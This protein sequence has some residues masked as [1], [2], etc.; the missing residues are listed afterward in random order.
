M[1]LVMG[2]GLGKSFWVF[3]SVQIATALGYSASS[4]AAMWW[5][6]SEHHKLVYVSFLFIPSLIISA[7]AQ[8]FVAPA[9]DRY[10]KKM[11]MIIGL[12]IQMTSYAVDTVLFFSGNMTLW[13]LIIFEIIAT[14]GKII[15]NSASI[16]ILP[17]IVEHEKITNG[18]NI[19]HRIN[20]TMSILGG[21]TGGSLV[22]FF[23]AAN[24]FLFLTVCVL[25]AL[26]LCFMIEFR[27]HDLKRR[28]NDKWNDDVREGILYTVRNKVVFG[29]FVYSLIIG[30]AFSPM[31]IAF[32]YLIKEIN[33][34]SPFFVGL[35]ASSMGI[36]VIVG[37]FLY[38]YMSNVLNNRF[39]V[40]ASSFMFFFALLLVGI[41]H[42]AVFIF[43]GQFLIGF[44]RNWINVT[45]DSLLLKHLPEKLRTRVLSNLM[46]FATINM[47]VAMLASGYFMDVMGVYNVLLILS[48][49]CF[50]AM[51]AIVSNKMVR[52][53]LS[54]G[55]EEAMELLRE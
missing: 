23:G 36:G 25:I 19:T 2:T 5:I 29:L 20:S 31:I 16:G 40:Y 24:S 47:P 27:T 48:G 41:M 17:H 37:S 45:I 18:M 13:Y 53:F 10:N 21:V 54:A 43:V 52:K 34:L 26:F 12:G 3:K 28:E 15:F 14:T 32:P 35:L 9:G 55:P 46:F 33:G 44:S 6:L 8:P 1:G 30:L 49:L 22:T 38:P 42:N 39:L 50:I 11:L 51:I 7:I 4:I